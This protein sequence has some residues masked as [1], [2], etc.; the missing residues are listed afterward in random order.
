MLMVKD[1]GPLKFYRENGK[2]EHITNYKL[3]QKHGWTI[4]YDETGK[5]IKSLLYYNDE[6][7]LA[8]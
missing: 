8:K 1:T 7:I 2:L 5:P 6:S 4:Y 3:G